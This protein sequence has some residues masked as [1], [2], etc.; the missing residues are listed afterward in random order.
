MEA[1][2]GKIFTWL[3]VVIVIIV[4]G[5]AAL[6]GGGKVWGWVWSSPATYTIRAT[7][8]NCQGRTDQGV[9]WGTRWNAP[10]YR[11]CR[12]GVSALGPIAG[13]GCGMKG[14]P[15]LIN[16]KALIDVGAWEALNRNGD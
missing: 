5:W 9:K 10:G 13:R 7:C 16:G 4:L 14:K 2:P 15:F 3:G 11:V 6:Y 1:E 8:T 12:G